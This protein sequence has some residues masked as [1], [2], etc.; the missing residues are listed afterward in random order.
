V[1]S[2]AILGAG[3]LGA[4]IAH[5]LAERARFDEVRLIDERESVAAGKALDIRQTGP[6]D[7]FDT[8]V[9]SAGDVLAAAGAS[10]VIVA[11][12]VDGGEWRGDAAL[13]LVGRLMRGGL[14]A[15]LVFAGADATWLI[16][17][18]AAELH[19]PADRMV[20]T[21]ASALVGTVRAFTALEVGASGVDVSVTVVGRPG[22]FVIGWSSAVIGGALVADRLAAHRMLAISDSLRKFWPPGPQSVAAPTARVAEAL[23]F[24]SRRLHQ[25]TAL[26]SE[27]TVAAGLGTRGRALMLPLSLGSGRILGQVPPTLSPQEKV[28][29]S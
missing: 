12:Q 10:V 5:Y 15:P 17:A 21:A 9:T 14:T 1:S 26:A 16:E 8:R 25:A 18:A 22:S 19:V 6:I 27:A 24:G 2:A 3:P 29:V 28:S 4:T 23:A 11:D 20:G 7:G 13:A